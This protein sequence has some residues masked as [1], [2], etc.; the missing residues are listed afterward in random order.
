MYIGTKFTKRVEGKSPAPA[1]IRRH[2]NGAIDID[3]YIRIGRAAHGAAVRDGGRLLAGWL[4]P[5]RRALQ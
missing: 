1:E 2:P 4:R 5:C 3:H